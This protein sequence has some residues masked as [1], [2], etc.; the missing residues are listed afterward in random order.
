MNDMQKDHVLTNY[1][2]AP[3]W[4]SSG[5]EPI[6]QH[7]TEPSAFLPFINTIIRVQVSTQGG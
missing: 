5:Q 7:P 3:I 4:R 1:C 6:G 2:F